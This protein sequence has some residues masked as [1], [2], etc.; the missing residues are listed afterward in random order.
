MTQ[1]LAQHLVLSSDGALFS[2]GVFTWQAVMLDYAHLWGQ[3]L[4][5]H[6]DQLHP[7]SVVSTGEVLTPGKEALQIVGRWSNADLARAHSVARVYGSRADWASGAGAFPSV[8]E[9]DRAL[10]YGVD[11]KTGGRTTRNV[12][13]A[14]VLHG[15]L[16][17]V[18]KGTNTGK[19][20]RRAP[21]YDLT[22]PTQLFYA[23]RNGDLPTPS[24][25]NGWGSKH[26]RDFHTQA[27]AALTP[28]P[29]G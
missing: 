2:T 10:G 16:R 13:T 27:V 23:I 29:H 24:G 4:K 17:Q 20:G 21:T 11:N 15:W 1:P 18:T 14:L 26:T 22:I 9:L 19:A 28:T 6:L 5:R 25:P 3:Y 8:A 7:L 12:R